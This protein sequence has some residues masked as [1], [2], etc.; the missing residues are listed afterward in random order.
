MLRFLSAQDT[1]LNMASARQGKPSL[2]DLNSMKELPKMSLGRLVKHSIF[3][4]TALRWA[5][6]SSSSD[7]TE[8]WCQERAVYLALLE[9]IAIHDGQGEQDRGAIPQLLTEALAVSFDPHVGH[10]YLADYNERYDFYHL[11]EETN[12]LRA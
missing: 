3:S 8:K 2:F 7:T 6:S 12:L 10:D 5:T 4:L 9:S 11:K 1:L